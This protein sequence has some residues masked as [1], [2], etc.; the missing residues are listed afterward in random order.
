M[1]LVA[2]EAVCHLFWM[3]LGEDEGVFEEIFPFIT[4][5]KGILGL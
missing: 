4:S 2:V 1:E 3:F 5:V